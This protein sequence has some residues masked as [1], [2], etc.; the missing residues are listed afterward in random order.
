MNELPRAVGYVC[1]MFKL[2]LEDAMNLSPE[3]LSFLLAWL[4]NEFGGQRRR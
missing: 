1:Y 4:D 2:S 3:Q